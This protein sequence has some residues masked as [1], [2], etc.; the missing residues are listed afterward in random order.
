M[1][2]DEKSSFTDGPRG[3][4]LT[5]DFDDKG[6]HVHL[7]RR[8]EDNPEIAPGAAIDIDA[9]DMPDE[10]VLAVHDD[11]EDILSQDRSSEDNFPS[12]AAGNV[13]VVDS[14]PTIETVDREV[15]DLIDQAAEDLEADTGN[16]LGGDNPNDVGEERA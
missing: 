3:P 11:D 9:G 8:D 14:D 5:H 13:E 10:G 4:A 1:S 16:V 6:T 2:A 15:P 12:D 7:P